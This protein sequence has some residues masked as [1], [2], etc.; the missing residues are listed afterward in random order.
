MD[1]LQERR[2]AQKASVVRSQPLTAV[3][4]IATS[5]TTIIAPARRIVADVPALGTVLD[6]P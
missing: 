2:A 6:R 5:R 4:A 1:V 3:A